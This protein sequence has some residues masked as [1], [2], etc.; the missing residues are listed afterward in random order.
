[1][2]QGSTFA[3][4]RASQPLFSN[5]NEIKLQNS[6]T[7]SREFPSNRHKSFLEPKNK[8]HLEGFT[9]IHVPTGLVKLLDNYERSTGVTEQVTAEELTEISLFLDAV[10]ETEVMKVHSASYIQFHLEAFSVHLMSYM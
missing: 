1:M 10:L 4:D 9:A 6:T 7:V 5:V 2:S 3:Q 8:A